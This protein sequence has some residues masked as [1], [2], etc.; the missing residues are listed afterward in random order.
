MNICIMKNP[1]SDLANVK[2]NVLLLCGF[3]KAICNNHASCTH[4]AKKRINTH[5]DELP[6]TL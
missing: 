5:M 6:N 3:F 1:T 2:L 4:S